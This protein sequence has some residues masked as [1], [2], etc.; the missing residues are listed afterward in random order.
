MDLSRS[1]ILIHIINK[2]EG[3]GQYNTNCKKKCLCFDI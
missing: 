3:P 1:H 2:C